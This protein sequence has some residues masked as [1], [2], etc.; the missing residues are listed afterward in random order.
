ME[1][2]ILI[3]MQA[4]G[5][6]TWFQARFA[7]TH[8]HISKDNFRNNSNR[9]KRQRFLIDE[10]LSQGRSVVIDNTNVSLQARAALIAQG[11]EFGARIVGYVLESHLPACLERNRLRQGVARVPDIALHIARANW[12]TPTLGEGFDALLHVR[13]AGEGVFEEIEEERER[14]DEQHAV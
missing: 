10:A 7:S 3:G 2:I 6:S 12:K 9:E 11:R 4:S 5:K 13:I 1:M 8:V 14:D